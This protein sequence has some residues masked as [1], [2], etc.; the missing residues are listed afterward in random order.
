MKAEAEALLDAVTSLVK[1]FASPDYYSSIC[2]EIES[3]GKEKFLTSNSLW[4]GSGSIADLIGVD[5]KEKQKRM[6]SALID[7][8]EYQI[9][10]GILNPRTE[11]WTNTFKSWKSEKV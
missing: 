5:D 8:G 3:E 11:M 6:E 7:L 1:E 10:E 4:G 9:S 2:A